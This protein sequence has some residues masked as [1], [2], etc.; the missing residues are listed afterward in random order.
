MNRHRRSYLK[1]STET[2]N[3]VHKLCKS[4]NRNKQ[5]VGRHRFEKLKGRM[6]PHRGGTNCQ[7]GIE[8]LQP[9]RIVDESLFPKYP[10]PT[11]SAK[12]SLIRT[13]RTDA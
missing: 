4:L 7:P 13:S 12:S 11:R 2:E 6:P 3:S 8:E 9:D 5:A 1:V 10:Y